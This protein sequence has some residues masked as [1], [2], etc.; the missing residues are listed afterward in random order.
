MILASPQGG[1]S[2]SPTLLKAE[3]GLRKGKTYLLVLATVAGVGGGL[4]AVIFRLMINGVQTLF[5][6]DLLPSVTFFA[7]K[8]NLGI[9][10]LPVIGAVIIAPVV[11][12]LAPETRGTGIP[13][14]LDAYTEKHGRIRTRVAV[15]KIVV[16]AITIGSG[17]SAGREGPITQIGGAT[18]SAMGRLL[19]LNEDQVKLLLVSGVAAGIAGTFNAPLGGALFSIEVLQRGFSWRGT[20]AIIIA[21]VVGAAVASLAFGVQPVLSAPTFGVLSA[22]QL[23]PYA[24]LGLVLGLLSYLWVKVFYSFQDVFNRLSLPGTLKLVIGGT[25][26]GIIGMLLPSYGILGVGYQGIDLILAGGVTLGL[27]LALGVAKVLATSLTIGSGGSGGVFAPTLYAGAMF[28]GAIG[29]VF[30][31][32]SPGIATQSFGYSLSGMAALIAGSARAPLTSIVIVPEMTGDWNILPALMMSC[33]ISYY[34]SSYLL[35]RSSIYTLKLEK[36]GIDVKRLSVQDYLDLVSVGEVMERLA[37]VFDDTTVATLVGRKEEFG[38]PRLAVVH[39][40]HTIVGYVKLSEAEAV[41][42][43]RREKTLVAAIANPD[44]PVVLAEESVRE[45]LKRMEEGGLSELFVVDSA[46]TRRYVGMFGADSLV[47]ARDLGI[48]RSE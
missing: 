1:R 47:K 32:L 28:G 11:Y 38:Y 15:L 45:A 40:D 23:A 18:G 46:V 35:N 33:I 10:L 13:E 41:P 36:R 44:A 42:P 20:P 2:K 31:K 24:V 14:I 16:S 3:S 48:E 37:P 30:V 17:G 27:A 43:E 26:V 29:Q 34:V 6:S 5:F 12:H 39:S 7:W 19:R 4:G 22:V 9:I 25:S 8:L 21:S